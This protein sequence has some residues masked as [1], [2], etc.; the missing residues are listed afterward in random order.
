MPETFNWEVN[1]NPQAPPMRGGK[2]PSGSQWGSPDEPAPGEYIVRYA[3]WLWRVGAGVIDY[4]IPALFTAKLGEAGTVLFV[5][6]VVLNSIVWQGA[7]GKSLGKRLLGLTLCYIKGDSRDAWDYYELPGR[8]RCAW[9]LLAHLLDL[10]LLYGLVWRPI[11]NWRKR[12]FARLS[13]ANR[14]DTRRSSS[15]LHSRGSGRRSE[16]RNIR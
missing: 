10:P 9:R 14:G 1:S 15:H 12:T 8:Q 3:G 11:F 16:P 4:L 7:T 13:R 2:T 6:W 5:G